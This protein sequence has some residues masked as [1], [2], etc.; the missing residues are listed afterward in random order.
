MKEGKEKSQGVYLPSDDRALCFLHTECT[1]LVSFKG[2]LI[3]LPDPVGLF[4][5]VLLAFPTSTSI[6][7]ILTSNAQHQTSKNTVFFCKEEKDDE[8][9]LNCTSCGSH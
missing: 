3:R 5:H 9:S 6:T 2:R 1:Q 4:T 8:I 7:S